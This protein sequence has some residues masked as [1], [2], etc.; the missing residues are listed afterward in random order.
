MKK[1]STVLPMLDF[2]KNT[3]NIELKFRIW[4]RIVN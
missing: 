2:L 4:Y 1:K 3:I